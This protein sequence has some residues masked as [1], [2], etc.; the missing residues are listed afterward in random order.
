MLALAQMARAPRQ[1]VRMTLLFAL[2]AAFVIFTLVYSASQAQRIP[3]VAAY[4]SGADFSGV[5]DN[6]SL[7][8]I[9]LKDETQA[10]QGISGVTSATLGYKTTAIGGG[11]ILAISIALM[12]VDSDNFA[13]TA[14]WPPQD[15]T[16]SLSSLM[17]QLTR[18]RKA[19]VA[20][21]AVPA[22]V[23]VS[24]WDALHLSPGATFTL[25]FFPYGPLTFTTLAE[26]QH[27]PTITDSSAGNS[28]D[29]T[30]PSGGVLVDY[31][32]FA[33]VYISNFAQLGTDLPINYAWLRTGDDAASLGSVRKALSTGCC[34]VLNQLNDRRALT[35][36]LQNDPLY[37]DLLGVLGI[38][39]TTAML[40]ALVGNLIA[41]WLSA[42]RRLTN[43]A[44]LRALGATPRQIASILTWEQGI[45]YTTAL[46]LGLLFGALFSFLA[47]PVMVFTS[48][49][50]SSSD[51]SS[52]TFYVVQNVP[53]ITIVIPGTL[54]IILS[55]LI[56]ICVIALGVMVRVVSKPSI[57]QTLRLNED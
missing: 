9:S 15:S 8:A 39:A 17:A 28:A 14:I 48:V 55:A 23:D 38:G 4:Q 24:T 41:S 21:N 27:I 35:A 44:V 18:Q 51:I 36:S 29:D 12:A 56:V 30:V 19:S 25:N 52:G 54:F 31:Q 7:T 46:A 22:I 5:L 11:N 43:F 40:L 32:T 37:L 16:Q 26:V 13:Q 3:E 33:P 50:S 1:S 10:Y 45:I 47:L 42:R 53:P 57:S 49:P 20:R 6:P 2:A 34:V